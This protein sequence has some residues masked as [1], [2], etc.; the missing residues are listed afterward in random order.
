VER[1]SRSVPGDRGIINAEV[2]MASTQEVRSREDVSSAF[3]HKGKISKVARYLWREDTKP[4]HFEWVDK[5]NLSVDDRYQRDL[6]Q[7]KVKGI[8]AKFSWP[9]FGVL[10]VAERSDGFYVVEGQHRLAAT[11]LRADVTDV[12][13]MVFES[14]SLVQEAEVFLGSNTW[15]RP[16]TAVA[17]F[18]ALR[19]V[20]DDPALLVEQLVKESGRTISEA[21][22]ATSIS[23]I[24]TLLDHAKVRPDTLKQAWP[25]ICAC[26][27][28]ERMPRVLVDGVV[29]IV[30][31]TTAG[32]ERRVARIA[33]MSARDLIESAYKN[34]GLHGKAGPKIWANG[35][36]IAIN[37]GLPDDRHLR[38]S[39]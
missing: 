16:P 2:H 29:Y 35:M 25:L 14:E 38:L 28:G 3:V 18:K 23:C 6:L 32:D 24:S 39:E 11:M 31:H 4:G 5:H 17:K 36:V 7:E 33:S 37:R 21:S 12:P 26:C 20:G 8:A 30:Q 10:I 19:V 27:A 34:A 1:F 13:C 9:I 15:R 22:S